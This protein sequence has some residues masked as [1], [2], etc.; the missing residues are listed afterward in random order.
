MNS[1][2]AGREV[3]CSS[4][5]GVTA[6]SA[7]NSGPF[8]TAKH[9]KVKSHRIHA[10]T[11]PPS[12]G[13]RTLALKYN[14]N[15]AALLHVCLVES[16]EYFNDSGL[17]RGIQIKQR[18]ETLPSVRHLRLGEICR[19]RHNCLSFSSRLSDSLM[20]RQII[21]DGY[22]H[23]L[24]VYEDIMTGGIRLHAA[25]WEGELRQCPVWTAFGLKQ[26]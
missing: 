17:T 2:S 12:Q 14:R 7:A 19:R 1:S 3:L 26:P 6:M 5:D 15:G 22:K 23:S 8:C 9:G 4:S 24:I 13:T 10:L 20:A 21:D 25:V 11:P 18:K 16:P